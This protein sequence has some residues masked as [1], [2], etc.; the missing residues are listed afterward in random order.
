MI[1]VMA[2]R[3][4]SKFETYVFG[5]SAAIRIYDELLMAGFRDAEIK[6]IQVFKNRGDNESEKKN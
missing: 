4:K 2:Q 3:G 5:A 1:R 6:M